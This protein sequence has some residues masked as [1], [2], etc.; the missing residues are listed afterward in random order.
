MRSVLPAQ[1]PA[2]NPLS[3]WLS[4][5]NW[6]RAK[7]LEDRL[8]QFSNLTVRDPLRDSIARRPC[9]AMPAQACDPTRRA[10]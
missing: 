1:E 6:N 2:E 4:A 3:D 10:P 9:H 7:A 5:E 8:E